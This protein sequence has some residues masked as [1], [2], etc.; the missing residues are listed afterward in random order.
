M[1]IHLIAVGTRMPAWVTQGYEEYAGRL[2]GSC[3]LVLREIPAGK[4]TRAADLAQVQRDEGARC[5]AAV[6]A[7]SRVIA[8][9]RAGQM[10]STEQLAQAMEGWMG[11]GRDVVFLVGGPEGLDK[12]CLDRANETWSLSA[13][14]LPHPLVRVVLAEQL[15]RAW[16]ILNH[17]PY[18]R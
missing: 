18:H 13:L 11:E 2:R 17:L 6:P 14:T 8:L 9:E 10:R 12:T 5:L 16:S 15:Y 1:Q 3:R 7:G 4:R